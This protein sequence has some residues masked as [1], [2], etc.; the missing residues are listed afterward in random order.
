MTL[1]NKITEISSNL[2]FEIREISK[3]TQASRTKTY[4]QSTLV[5]SVKELEKQ[6]R[7]LDGYRNTIESPIELGDKINTVYDELV[8]I[9]EA[10][11]EVQYHLMHSDIASASAVLTKISKSIRR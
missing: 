9:A 1:L 3:C 7:Q 4:I 10:I 5:D 8:A 2:T 6:N 11:G